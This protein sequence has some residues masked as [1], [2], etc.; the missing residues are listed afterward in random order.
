MRRYTVGDVPFSTSR[1]MPVA[2]PPDA[3]SLQTCNALSIAANGVVTASW[4][5]AW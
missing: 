5:G 3:P 4:G 1:S 2:S